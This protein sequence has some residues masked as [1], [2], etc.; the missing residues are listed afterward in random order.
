[1]SAF[2]FGVNPIVLKAG[3]NKANPSVAVLIG[4][5]SGL[6]LLVLVAPTLGG[7]HFD[8]LTLSAAIYFVLGGLFGIVFGR[9]ALYWSIKELGS[10]RA[11][12]FKNGAPVVTAVLAIIFL[13]EAIAASRWGAILLVTIGLTMIGGMV[14]RLDLGSAK[15][16][17]LMVALLPPLFYGIR[18]IFS[19]IGLNI[20]PLPLAATFIGY[21]AA[22]FLYAV[23]FV[24]W[25]DS[26]AIR[27][28]RRNVAFF[29]I[30]G[31]LQAGGLLLL[32]FALERSDVSRIYPISASAPLVTFVLSYIVLKNIERLTVWDLVGT[33]SVVGG[34]IWLLT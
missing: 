32:N 14:Q 4:L 15:K 29:A 26:A 8:E 18:P 7:F 23:Y 31:F 20:T 24:F 19:K 28:G 11:S 27:V 17:A 6:P 34:V 21:A 10:T 22:L 30:A 16:T 5:L 25:Q 33:L 13:S 3:L 1:M 9:A 2:C 12:T